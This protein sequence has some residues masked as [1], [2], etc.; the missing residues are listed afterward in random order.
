[1]V[2]FCGTFTD[3]KIKRKRKS[4]ISAS[5]AHENLVLGELLRRGF[6]AQLGPTEHE[7]LV[8]AGDSLP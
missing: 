2:P 5:S 4:R 8:R 3:E 1:M 7:V 6:D